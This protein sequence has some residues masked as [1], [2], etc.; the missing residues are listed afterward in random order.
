MT[1]NRRNG[2][3]LIELMIAMAM[4]T[5]LLGALAFGMQSSFKTYSENDRVAQSTQAARVVLWRLISEVRTAQ[6]ITTNGNSIRI[7]PPQPDPGN[8]TAI[9]YS[10]TGGSLLYT[11]T[12]GAT[13]LPP[14]TLMGATEEIHVNS[15]L[16]AAETGEDADGNP[17]IVNVIITLLITDGVET[18]PH[19]VTVAPRRS[20]L[21]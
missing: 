18:Y 19:T 13:P 16:V 21:F 10:F 9:E 6:S 12:V 3:T 1:P 15:F 11:Q 20:Q 17:A 14:N 8:V 5:V 4:A 7:V 2:F